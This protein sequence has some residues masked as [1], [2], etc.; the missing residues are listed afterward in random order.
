MEFGNQWRTRVSKQ[1]LYLND[2]H[3]INNTGESKKVI[4]L[5]QVLP[6]PGNQ[7]YHSL[8]QVVLKK[9]NGKE[10]KDIRELFQIATESEGPFLVIEL[11]DE[12]E[13]VFEKEEITNLNDEAIKVFRIPKSQNLSE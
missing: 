1:L 11:D 10:P 2:Y 9:V 13:V 8:Q 3:N 4:L 12:T 7:A 5:S 6:L